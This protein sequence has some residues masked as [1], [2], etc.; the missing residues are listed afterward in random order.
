MTDTMQHV[1]ETKAAELIAVKPRTLRRW[2]NDGTVPYRRFGKLV[3]YHIPS[4]LDWAA[5]R[6]QNH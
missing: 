5:S 3:R 6:A 2:R 1:T 4:L